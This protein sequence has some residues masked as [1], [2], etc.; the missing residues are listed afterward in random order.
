MN[1]QIKIRLVQPGDAPALVAIYAPYVLHTAVTFEYEVPTAEEFAGRIRKV[2]TRFPYL[3]A[4]V[5]GEIAGYAYAA[6][7]GERK[8]FDWTVETSIYIKEDKK[9]LGLGR[10]LYSALEDILKQQNVLNLIARI[11]Y[12][13]PEDEYLTVDSVRFHEHLGYALVGTAHRCGYKFDHW[14]HMVWMEKHLGPHLSGHPAVIPFSE[15]RGQL[16]W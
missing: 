4:E 3:V 2:L 14:Y 16:E 7:Y 13:E 8:A 5:A 15:I 1:D 11:A 10:M 12:P 9:G 6:P